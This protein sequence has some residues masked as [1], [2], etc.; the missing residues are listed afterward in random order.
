MLASLALPLSAFELRD[1]V[2]QSRRFD[3]VRLDR[4]LRLDASAGLVEVQASAT[5]A[6]LAAHLR[7][8]SPEAA[9]AWSGLG[10]IGESIA[11]NAAGPDGRPVVA[12]I[13]SLA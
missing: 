11:T 8:G 4:V 10:T 5:W 12:H 6:S 13:E 9:E 1:A 3:P 2:R 7:P